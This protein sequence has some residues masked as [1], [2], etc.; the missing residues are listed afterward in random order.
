MHVHTSRRL[1][2]L[3]SL[4]TWK[5]MDGILEGAVVLCVGKLACS[6]LFLP[7]L[8][9][10][11]SP[12]SFCCC[13][14]LIF[15]DFLVAVFLSLLCVAESW[16]TELDPPGDVVALRFLLFLSHT[17][18]A[19]LHLTTFLVCVEALIK[20]LW[21]H[22]AADHGTARQTAGSDG[23]PRCPAGG[24]VEEE[25][26]GICCPEDGGSWPQVVGFLCCLSA[27]VS[28]ALVVRWHL[29]ME[30]VWAAVCLHTTNSLIG[31]LPN[32]YTPTPSA[33]NPWWSMAFLLFLLL[34][35]TT[36]AGL[37]GVRR[38]G[39]H[40][41]TGRRDCVT[42]TPAPS[43]H[44]PLGT[45]VT[46][47][48]KTDRAWNSLQMS[49]NPYGDVDLFSRDSF[50]EKRGRQERERTKTGV[51]L[52]FVT[53]EHMDSQ[54]SRWCGWQRWG[55]PSLE[56]NV[57]IGLLGFLPIFILPFILSVNI[58]LIRTIDILLES[59]IQSLKSSAAKTRDEST[60]LNVTQV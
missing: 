59:C 1:R 34:L 18:G 2:L 52:A 21:P 60:S 38:G 27:W 8:A 23:R 20:L 42:M 50:P 54:R 45:P 51:P 32:L 14:L 9:A 47:P 22:A 7:S 15:T 37:R 48:E 13:C 43:G 40:A 3:P 53:E 4:F 11:Y 58:L 5:A 35:L 49:A 30:E 31:C 41:S 6:L 56:G 17:Y 33:V 25:E 10:S 12:V 55:F 16:L 36:G 57:M 39:K 24:N 29:K 44:V 28:V 26:E 19:V 46:D